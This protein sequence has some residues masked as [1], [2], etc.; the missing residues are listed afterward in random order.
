MRIL[1]ITPIRF[2]KSR[3]S[4]GGTGIVDVKY[5]E[6]CGIFWLKT[7]TIVRRAAST[8]GVLWKWLDSPNHNL[9]DLSHIIDAC[10]HE[11]NLK[12]TIQISKGIKQ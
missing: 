8:T 1:E 6:R 10:S 7:R 2:E 11:L 9:H 3:Y 4:S 12:E 5:V